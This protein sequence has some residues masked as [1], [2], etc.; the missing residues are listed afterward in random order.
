VLVVPF[1]TKVIVKVPSSKEATSIKEK[2]FV[3]FVA[4]TVVVFTTTPAWF[5]IEIVAVVALSEEKVASKAGLPA[6]ITLIPPK[7]VALAVAKMNIAT[8]VVNK[9]F[10]FL[11]LLVKSLTVCSNFSIKRSKRIYY[12]VVVVFF[13]IYFLFLVI[14]DTKNTVNI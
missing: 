11:V 2:V 1:A 12:C 13:L 5:V 9:A 4:A 14:I 7:S 6:A 3:P 10:I 8:I